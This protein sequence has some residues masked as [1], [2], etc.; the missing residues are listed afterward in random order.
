MCIFS[1]CLQASIRYVDRPE[2]TSEPD[3][4]FTTAD[5]GS[6]RAFLVDQ[7]LTLTE[8]VHLRSGLKCAGRSLI[9]LAISVSNQLTNAAQEIAWIPNGQRVP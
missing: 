7:D 1:V 9:P 6:P 8:T 5:I 4:P 2:I 3:R